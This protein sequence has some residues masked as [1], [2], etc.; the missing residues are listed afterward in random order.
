MRKDPNLVCCVRLRKIF[1]QLGSRDLNMNYALL[2]STRC[3]DAVSPLSAGAG[4]EHNTLNV[5]ISWTDWITDLRRRPKYGLKMPHFRVKIETMCYLCLIPPSSYW[6][7]AVTR[8]NWS[9]DQL[10]Q[11][12]PQNVS[13]DETSVVFCIIL[14]ILNCPLELSGSSWFFV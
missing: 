12:W 3:A 1:P 7:S 5:T 9:L 2:E 8:S 11:G 14:K 6:G 4:K 13:K 10:H